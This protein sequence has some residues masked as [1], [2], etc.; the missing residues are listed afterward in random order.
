MSYRKNQ[1]DHK[2]RAMSNDLTL[3]QKLVAIELGCEWAIT[4]FEY[5]HLPIDPFDIPTDQHLENCIKL[6]AAGHE[7]RLTD[8]EWDFPMG[9]LPSERKL[10]LGFRPHPTSAIKWLRG[11]DAIRSSSPT[12]VVIPDPR[13]PDQEPPGDWS[14]EDRRVVK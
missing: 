3:I 1:R 6:H 4:T 8:K 14:P 12:Y 7:I 9:Y 11:F 13:A 5:S 2:G 10:W